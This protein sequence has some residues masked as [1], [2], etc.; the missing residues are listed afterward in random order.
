MQIFM[1]YYVL[2]S[3]LFYNFQAVEEEL[4]RRQRDVDSLNKIGGE[5][6]DK[7]ALELVEPELLK[8]NKRW[9]DIRSQSLLYRHPIDST[10]VVAATSSE[11]LIS[12][13]T[14]SVVSSGISKSATGVKTPSQY[15]D[16]VKGVLTDILKV[17]QLLHSQ[18][19]T[20]RDFEDFSKQ[21]DKLKVNYFVFL[22]WNY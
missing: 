10:A 21:E 1:D 11:S 22:F 3:F 9:H 14:A 7:E 6:K 12:R 2:F 19:L 15:I 13:T 8:L 5:L 20:G 18:E 16:E 4:K 17:Q